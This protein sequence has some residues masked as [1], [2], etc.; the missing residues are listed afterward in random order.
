M[1]KLLCAMLMAM[2]VCSIAVFA[3]EKEGKEKADPNV[4]KDEKIALADL[5][6]VIVDAVNAARPGGTI[7]EADKETKKD[8][9]VTYE[10]DTKLGG[11][12]YEVIVDA[13]GKVLSNKEDNDEDDKEDEKKKDVKKEEAK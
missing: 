4:V 13:S 11:K 1:T 10:V 3:E 12:K 7:V 8:G 2:C 6:K 9:S 5:P